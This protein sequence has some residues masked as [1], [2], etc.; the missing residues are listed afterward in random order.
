[1]MKISQSLA[2]FVTLCLLAS[3]QVKARDC[4]FYY[5]DWDRIIPRYRNTHEN[6]V[7]PIPRT[8]RASL[9]YVPH[10]SMEQQA[11]DAT[12][13]VASRRS[14]RKRLGPSLNGSAGGR[15]SLKTIVRDILQGYMV[16]FGLGYAGGAAFSIPGLLFQPVVSGTRQ[17]P[18]VELRG[19]VS[20]AASNSLGWGLSVGEIAATYKGSEHIVRKIRYPREDDY[21]KIYGGMLGG[22]IYSRLRKY[23]RDGGSAGTFFLTEHSHPSL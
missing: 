5:D 1:M 20:R 13:L 23:T 12:M 8:R 6:P 2:L 16:G 9:H 19:R 7:V 21:N 3:K 18:A 14:V 11:V 10:V 17:A 22:A 15:A 4:Q